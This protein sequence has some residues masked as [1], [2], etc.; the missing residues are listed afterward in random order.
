MEDAIRFV[1]KNGWVVPLC[2]AV[3]CAGAI[4]FCV[5]YAHWYRRRYPNGAPWDDEKGPR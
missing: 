3:W 1:G 4:S 2:L 5:W